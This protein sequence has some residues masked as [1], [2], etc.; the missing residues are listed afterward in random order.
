WTYFHVL[1]DSFKFK[2]GDPKWLELPRSDVHDDWKE[3]IGGKQAGNQPGLEEEIIGGLRGFVRGAG[4]RTEGMHEELGHG[5]ALATPCNKNWKDKTQFQL[6]EEMWGKGTRIPLVAMGRIKDLAGKPTDEKAADV[7]WNARLVWDWEEPEP[8]RLEKIAKTTKT[9]HSGA[10]D[11]EFLKRVLKDS[12]E[13]L[14]PKGSFNCPP[15]FGGK[16]GQDDA[17]FF[18]PQPKKGS[19]NGSPPYEIAPLATRKWAVVTRFDDKGETGA[20]LFPSRFAGDAYK[21]KTYLYREGIDTRD[22][23]TDTAVGSPGSFVVHR[24]LTAH[25]PPPAA[26]PRAR[27]SKLHPS[28]SAPPPA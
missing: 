18:V 3:V 13:K 21:V 28:R 8:K 12:S 22:P 16:L 23:I 5:V 27:P 9:L 25:P 20:I 10:P 1:V 14:L 19:G 7:M 4:G 11:L 2:F 17:P 26:L 24:R 15:E 6:H